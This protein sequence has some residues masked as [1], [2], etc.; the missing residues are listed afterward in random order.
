ML[1]SGM[2]PSIPIRTFVLGG[3]ALFTLKS[4]KTGKHFTYRVNQR[5]QEK[6]A[7]VSVLTG[8]NNEED[9]SFL[10]TIFRDGNYRHGTKSHIGSDAPSNLAFEWFWRHADRLPADQVEFCH[11]GKCAVCG[12][13]LTTP[14]SLALGIGPECAKRAGV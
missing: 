4:L 1:F 9:Y 10:G 12:R 3:K 8:S 11:C 2:T 14:D 7:F 6:P 13:T 5:S